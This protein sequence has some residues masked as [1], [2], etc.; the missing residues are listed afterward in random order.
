MTLAPWAASIIAVAR[1]MPLPAP[2]ITTTFDKSDMVFSSQ[3]TEAGRL[4]GPAWMNYAP[5]TMSSSQSSRLD[6]DPLSAVLMTLGIRVGG[7]NRLEASGSWG[8]TF[9]MRP[10]FKI[11]ACLKGQ[12]WIILPGQAATELRRG[13]VFLVGATAY[14]I[15]SDPQASLEDGDH[16]FPNPSVSIARLDGEETVL[17]GVSITFARE[18]AE[19][20][21]QTLPPFVKIEADAPQATAVG[22]TL[23]L[24]EDEAAR[25]MMGSALVSAR[26]A[27]ILFVEAL[28][29]AVKAPGTPPHGWIA[30]LAD[31]PIGAALALMHQDCARRWTV[32]MLAREVGLSRSAFAARFQARVGQSP[33]AYLTRWRLTLARMLLDHPGA[34]IAGISVDVGYDSASAF[35]HAFKRAFGHSPRATPT[36]PS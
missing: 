8:L 24:L 34:T 3:W 11:V 28:R 35:S 32:A 22:R 2:V 29:A 26:L 7:Q 5:N 17:M 27:E 15:A 20:L 31:P 12:C 1:P 21:N 9:P 23:A 33:L 13:D 16:H 10:R 25:D 18:G 36:I 14:G 30:A 6:Q 4:V 19:L